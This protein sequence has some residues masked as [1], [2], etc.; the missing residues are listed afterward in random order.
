M[1]LLR[2]RLVR[3]LTLRQQRCSRRS[4]HRARRLGM[5]PSS[6]ILRGIRGATEMRALR[7]EGLRGRDPTISTQEKVDRLAVF[8]D[9]TIQVVPSAANRN[10]GL[11]HSPRG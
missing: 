5:W 6:V 11:V 3:T 2:Y 9:C 4:S 7:K 1:T 10:V 8:V